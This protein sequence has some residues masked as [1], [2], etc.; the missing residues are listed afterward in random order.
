MRIAAFIAILCIGYV[1]DS[2]SAIGMEV[3]TRCGLGSDQS[4]TLALLRD[5]PIDSTSVFYLSK[6]STA[7]VRLYAGT[8]I[9]RGAMKYRWHV[10]VQRSAYS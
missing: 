2:Q 5:H 3:V 6:N 8:R 9:N 10:S 1:A 4:H 7:P